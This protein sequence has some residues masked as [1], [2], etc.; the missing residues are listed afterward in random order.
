MPAKAACPGKMIQLATIHGSDASIV[1]SI[2]QK[3]KAVVVHGPVSDINNTVAEGHAFS[4][5][6]VHRS[7]FGILCVSW[8]LLTCGNAAQ[9]S[10]KELGEIS[11]PIIDMWQCYA[12]ECEGAG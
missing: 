8:C 3:L 2:R 11:G 7:P 12:A 10:V 6:V 5:P 1:S 9:M 4:S